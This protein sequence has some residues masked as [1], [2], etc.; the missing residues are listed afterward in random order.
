MTQQLI[1]KQ[2]GALA[3]QIKKALPNNMDPDRF[4]RVVITALR[5][6]PTLAKCT[7]ESLF[8]SI[9]QSAQM[10]LEPS[11]GLGKSYLI[12]YFNKKNDQYECQLQTGYKGLLDLAY[13]S[14]RIRSIYAA[15]VNSQDDFVYSLGTDPK[16]DHR[17]TDQANIG[18]M[19]HVY[20]VAFLKD[21]GYQFE[22]MSRDQVEKIRLLSPS[23]NSS[24][25][26][27]WYDEMA[28][29]KV[30]KRL[31]KVLP[32]SVEIARA[33][34]LDDQL[35][36]GSI[37]EFDYSVESAIQDAA[38]PVGWDEPPKAKPKKSRLQALIKD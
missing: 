21:G 32:L 34:A 9:L 11:D 5:K 6:N 27:K 20:A 29:A 33:V 17:P 35:E 38:L 25:W 16:I 24:P 26:S 1:I 13:R 22:V 31:C 7:I 18:P 14:G 19:T 15:V 3:S 10:G 2:V 36:G 23:K 12:P 8:G 28:K 37:Q 30:L 4:S